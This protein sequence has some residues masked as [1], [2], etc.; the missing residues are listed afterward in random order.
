MEI[1]TW[2]GMFWVCTLVVRHLFTSTLQNHA[3]EKI[4]E[5]LDDKIR[6]VKLEMV[7]DAKLLLAYDEENHQFL[8][9]GQD[10]VEVIRNLVTRFPSKIFLVEDE[11][12]SAES[13]IPQI[14]VV[15]Q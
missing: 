6:V 3:V 10:K 13:T 15:H 5:Q 8:A 11:A 14:K 12:Y 4:K 2:L 9:Q 1:F 7:A